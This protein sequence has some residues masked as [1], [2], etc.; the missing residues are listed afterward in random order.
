MG[1]MT[2]FPSRKKESRLSWRLMGAGDMQANGPGVKRTLLSAGIIKNRGQ[3]CPRYL[4]RVP[5]DEVHNRGA[6]LQSMRMMSAAGF[7]DE[8]DGATKLAIATGKKKRVF[9]RRH[10]IVGVAKDMEQWDF[11]FGESLQIVDRVDLRSEGFLVAL[12]A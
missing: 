2:V 3:E 8:F 10:H 1:R 6:V 11:S 9:F 7:G 5:H 4:V 12:E